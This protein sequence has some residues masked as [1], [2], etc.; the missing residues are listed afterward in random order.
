[1]CTITQST[2]TLIVA[3][4]EVNCGM[5]REKHVMF[6]STPS[7]IMF[8]TTTCP[9]LSPVMAGTG[10]LRPCVSTCRRLHMG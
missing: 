6:L 7:V 4:K 1:M 3:F 9:H 8:H 5:M 2:A 10:P